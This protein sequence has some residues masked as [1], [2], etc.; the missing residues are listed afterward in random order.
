MDT[1]NVEN[2]GGGRRGPSPTLSPESMSFLGE[3]ISLVLSRW[4]ALQMA[5]ENGWG[6]RDSRRKADELADS[7]LSLFV[8]SKAP[9]YIDDLENMIDESMVVSF[10]TE[11]EDGSVEEIAEEL[12]IM[13]E[14]CLKG[15]YEPIQKLRE[16][17]PQRNAVSQSRQLIDDNEDESSEEEELAEMMVDDAEPKETTMDQPKPSKAM[18]DEEGWSVVAPRRSRGRN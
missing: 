14:D 12:M 5:V 17:G 4:T 10:N 6:G 9:L 16:A 13:H 8:Q 18:P 7:I 3:G 15:N 2:G 1:T 11:I